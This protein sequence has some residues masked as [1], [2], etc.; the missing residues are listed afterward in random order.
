MSSLPATSTSSTSVS[1]PSATT[2]AT[3]PRTAA[4]ASGPAT[5]AP[6][7]TPASRSKTT[8]A[9]ATPGARATANAP[10]RTVATLDLTLSPKRPARTSAPPARSSASKASSATTSSARTNPGRQS[11]RPASTTSSGTTSS[12]VPAN[13]RIQLELYGY[14]RTKIVGVRFYNG[15]ANE[16]EKVYAV[17]QPDNIYDPNAIRI[18]DNHG[19]CIGHLSRDEA[20]SLA[21]FMDGD[22]CIFEP[23]VLSNKS[24][25]TWPAVLRVIGPAHPSTKRRLLGEFADHMFR[26]ASSPPST[27]R[28]I[29]P[30]PSLYRQVT[31][32]PA[33]ARAPPPASQAYD[34]TLLSDEYDDDFD[35]IREDLDI[36]LSQTMAFDPRRM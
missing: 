32:P 7:A 24:N 4:R 28:R 25:F 29:P 36:M 5:Q 27:L 31:P 11:R 10:K 6:A 2:S 14:I 12:G 26:L 17:R 1:T 18:D 15:Y 35:D 3:A 22:E 16:G 9:A 13:G 33:S 19:R 21:G 20:R 23:I 34:E 8:A 30:M